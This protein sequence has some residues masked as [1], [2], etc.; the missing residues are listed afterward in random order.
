M[1]T[2]ALTPICG[3]AMPAPFS[4]RMVSSMSVMRAASSA[5][6][7]VTGAATARSSGSP[8]FSTARTAIPLRQLELQRAELFDAA[9][10]FIA[11]LQPH[12]LFLRVAE[13]DALGRPRPDDVTGLKGPHPGDVGDQLLRV[14]DHPAG[15]G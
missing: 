2:R 1:T 5:S 11:G 4:A 7:R 6:K 12:L 14:K 13:N 10:D 15:V 3:A 8:I 9:L